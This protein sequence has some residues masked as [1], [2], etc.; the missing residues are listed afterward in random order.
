MRALM[1]LRRPRWPCSPR[2]QRPEPA[3]TA[4]WKR[5]SSTSSPGKMGDIRG[6]FSYDA[7]PQIVV[8]QD[9]MFTG[10]IGI[11]TARLAKHRPSRLRAS[12]R[13]TNARCPRIIVY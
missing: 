10:S 2:R 7:K 6:G 12:P 11:E 4:S 3:T 8:G 5:R 9:S 1:I 13:P